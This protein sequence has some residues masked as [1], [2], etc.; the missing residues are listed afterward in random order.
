MALEYSSTSRRG[1]NKGNVDDG[2]AQSSV[3]FVDLHAKAS[4]Q[5]W[6][7]KSKLKLD[8]ANSSPENV[9]QFRVRSNVV[10]PQRVLAHKQGK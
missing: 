7:Y 6:Q 2:A 9:H 10:R 1:I 4:H 8:S 5:P 3:S